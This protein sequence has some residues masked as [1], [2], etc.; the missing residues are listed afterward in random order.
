MRASWSAGGILAMEDVAHL[1]RSSGA[2]MTLE[3]VVPGAWSP[4]LRIDLQVRR[5]SA[6]APSRGEGGR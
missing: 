3:A 2:P 4:M 1:V 6:S 5:L